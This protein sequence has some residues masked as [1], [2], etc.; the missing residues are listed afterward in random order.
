MGL[1]EARGSDGELQKAIEI[2]VSLAKQ[3]PEEYDYDLAMTRLKLY[4][5]KLEK[6][7]NESPNTPPSIM[8]RSRREAAKK[9]KLELAK[10]LTN[11]SN[12]F[13]GTDL[14][15]LTSF[16]ETIRRPLS[17]YC[18]MSPDY[19]LKLDQTTVDHILDS[20]EPSCGNYLLVT[21]ESGCGKSSLLSNWWRRLAQNAAK[22]VDISFFSILT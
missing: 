4:T 3:F 7:C 22:H 17:E 9:D 21:G 18:T 16:K 14:V 12:R 8:T 2:R 1:L 11:L 5:I 6:K 19:Y 13:L 20:G 10:C 15:H